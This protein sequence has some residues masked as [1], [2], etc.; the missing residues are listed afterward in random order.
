MRFFFEI[1]SR[2]NDVL[3]W[4]PKIIISIDVDS[5]CMLYF[6]RRVVFYDNSKVDSVYFRRSSRHDILRRR[7]L[8]ARIEWF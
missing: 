8:L 2:Y 4:L 6:P 7:G 3:V 5:V 1:M